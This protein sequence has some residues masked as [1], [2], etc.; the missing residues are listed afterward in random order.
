MGPAPLG[1]AGLAQAP[2]L[3]QAPH[4]TPH[5]APLLAPA[6]RLGLPGSGLG[7]PPGRGEPCHAM[8]VGH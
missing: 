5:T 6:G 4:S 2:R 3:G 8:E 1:C 7:H